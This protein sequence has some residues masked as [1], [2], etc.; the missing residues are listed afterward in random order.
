MNKTSRTEEPLDGDGLNQ[1]PSPFSSDLTTNNDFNGLTNARELLD[2]DPRTIGSSSQGFK[3]ETVQ[4]DEPSNGGETMRKLTIGFPPAGQPLSME[5]A[6]AAT[7]TAVQPDAEGNGSI[8]TG[9]G[10]QSVFSRTKHVLICFGKFVG[11]GFMISVAYSESLVPFRILQHR[12]SP[13]HRC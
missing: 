13:D 9:R 11:P 2:R 3:G 4:N 10:S 8:S 6:A 1:N 7:A 12:V 5:V